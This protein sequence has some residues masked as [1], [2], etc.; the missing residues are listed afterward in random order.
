MWSNLDKAITD[1]ILGFE[2]TLGDLDPQL[3]KSI[4]LDNL[5]VSISLDQ[6]SQPGQIRWHV[7]VMKGTE[8]LC[9]LGHQLEMQA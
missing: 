1:F 3:K 9:D 2:Q 8:E 4:P 7:S 5:Q 6:R